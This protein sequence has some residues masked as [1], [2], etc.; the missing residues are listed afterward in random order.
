VAVVKGAWF[1][2]GVNA[3]LGVLNLATGNWIALAAN[4][5]ASAFLLAGLKGMEAAR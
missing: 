5:V 3:G 1:F 4:A 2:L